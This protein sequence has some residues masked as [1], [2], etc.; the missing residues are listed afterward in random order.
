M[1]KG[2]F[3][4]HLMEGDIVVR[5][6]GRYVTRPQEVERAMEIKGNEGVTWHVLRSRSIVE[7]SL[8][9]SWRCS[10]GTER[11][12]VF[13]GIVLRRTPRAVAERGGSL[14]GAERGLYFWYVIAGSP[15][16]T[17]GVPCP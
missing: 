11:L 3:D 10:D 7:C 15:A 8:R 17:F 13:N 5:V 4:G 1:Q 14:K 6:D 16:D 12:I 9:P 2:E